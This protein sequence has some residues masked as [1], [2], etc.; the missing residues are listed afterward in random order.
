MK[1]DESPNLEDASAIIKINNIQNLIEY[2]VHNINHNLFKLSLDLQ[3]LNSMSALSAAGIAARSRKLRAPYHFNTPKIDQDRVLDL[4]AQLATLQRMKP[5]LF[6]VWHKLFDNGRKAY[7]TSVAGNLSHFGNP[8]AR[9]FSFYIETFAQGTI[10]DIGTGPLGIPTYLSSFPSEAVFGVEPLAQFGDGNS[11]I[12]CGLNEFLPWHD[13]QFDTVISGTSLDHVF[14]L[15]KSLEEVRRVLKPDG[16]YLLWISSIAG[17]P[18]FNENQERFEA[19]DDFHLFH[20]DREWIEPILKDHFS[21]AD[22]YIIPQ[23]GY[24]NVFYCLK[25]SK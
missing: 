20:F 2:S 15:Q 17:S 13:S 22:V 25:N 23:A 3:T 16:L 9:A 19:I 4:D 12:F 21:I 10:L 11:S 8:Y 5:V 18:A 7:E 24:D 1:N 6:E 14:S